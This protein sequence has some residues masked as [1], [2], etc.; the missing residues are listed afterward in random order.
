MTSLA[1][2]VDLVPVARIEQMISD[3]GD[4]FLERVFT[5]GERAQA[6]RVVRGRGERYAARFAAKEAVL[7]ALGTGLSGGITWQDI[8]VKRTSAGA[9]FVEFSGVAA[10]K[11]SSLGLN[12]WRLTLSHA[13]GLAIA[14]VVASG[15]VNSETC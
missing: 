6:E 13:G 1:H 11:A 10:E 2:G 8:D 4:R 5:T 7:K 3:H 12:T 9:P 14:S 15:Q